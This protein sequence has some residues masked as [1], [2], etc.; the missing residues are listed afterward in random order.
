MTTVSRWPRRPSQHPSTQAPRPGAL[1]CC[2]R[3]QVAL[4]TV[5]SMFGRLPRPGRRAAAGL[6]VAALCATSVATTVAAPAH[7][8]EAAAGGSFYTSFEDSDPQLTWSNTV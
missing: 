1:H 3:D 4:L 6:A 5:P 2:R 8:A 7:A